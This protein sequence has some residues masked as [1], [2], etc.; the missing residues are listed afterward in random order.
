[1]VTKSNNHFINN[2]LNSNHYETGIINHYPGIGGDGGVG[3][4]LRNGGRGEPTE[5]ESSEDRETKEG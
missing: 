4:V 5:H 1:M 2:N 3:R